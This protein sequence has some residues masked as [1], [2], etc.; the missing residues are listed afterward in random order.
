MSHKSHHHG[1]NHAATIVHPPRAKPEPRAL[2][3]PGSK[4]EAHTAKRPD[5]TAVSVAAADSKETSRKTIWSLIL[6]GIGV[7]V[8][9]SV[10]AYAFDWEWTGFPGNTVWDWM[11]LLLV[12]VALHAATFWYSFERKRPLVTQ[13]RWY[14][15]IGIGL[16]VALIAVIMTAYHF[17]WMWTGFLGEPTSP[18]TDPK[19]LWDWL[20]VLLLPIAVAIATIQIAQRRFAA[21][22]AAAK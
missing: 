2:T 10:A 9:F 13:Q 18:S 5:F 11:N 6:I 8:G 22:R 19:K 16:I 12:P 4:S 14:W 7:F 20:N 15:A 3:I 1:R 21:A 17:E